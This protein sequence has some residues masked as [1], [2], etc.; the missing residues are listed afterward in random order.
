MFNPKLPQFVNNP[1]PI[2]QGHVILDNDRIKNLP[3]TP[4]NLISSIESEQ[5]VLV[6]E[7]YVQ[8]Y[9]IAPYTNVDVDALLF[10]YRGNAISRAAC[11]INFDGV[12]NIAGNT[13]FIIAPP[14]GVGADVFSPDS[15]P[16]DDGKTLTLH[17]GS[18]SGPLTG[19]NIANIMKISFSYSLLNIVTGLFE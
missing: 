12:M 19:G 18:F 5:I 8:A 11:P 9:F 17:I 15:S 2:Y 7:G 13:R 4:I 10:F 16:D 1:V 14:V 6:N 3:D